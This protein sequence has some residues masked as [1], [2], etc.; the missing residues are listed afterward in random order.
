MAFGKPF[1]GDPGGPTGRGVPTQ[2]DEASTNNVTFEEGFCYFGLQILGFGR[3]NLFQ[4]LSF[5]F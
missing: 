2:K 3:S 4:V 5:G 1:T